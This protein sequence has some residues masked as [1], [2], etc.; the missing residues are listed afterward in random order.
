MCWNG[1]IDESQRKGGSVSAAFALQSSGTTENRSCKCAP[2]RAPIS[3]ER[4]LLSRWLI[5]AQESLVSRPFFFKLI[6]FCFSQV[7]QGR[8][9]LRSHWG[10]WATSVSACSKITRRRSGRSMNR[11]LTQNLQVKT[12]FLMSKNYRNQSL[13]NLVQLFQQWISDHVSL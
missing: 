10:R 7:P 2:G 11:S 8:T 4:T 9:S 13:F 3:G 1:H 6:W 12:T 5:I